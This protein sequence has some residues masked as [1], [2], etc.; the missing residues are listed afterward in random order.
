M[1]GRPGR[2]I[3]IAAIGATLVAGCGGAVVEVETAEPEPEPEPVTDP[4]ELAR[5]GAEEDAAQG[6]WSEAAEGFER[7]YELLDD[8]EMLYR[9]ALAFTKAEQWSSA[10]EKFETYLVA[11]RKRISP[12]RAYEIGAELD[13]LRAVAAGE[14]PVTWQ[15]LADQVYDQ[16]RS[17]DEGPP[18]PASAGGSGGA[19]EG[20]TSTSAT[21]EQ[22]LFY[23]GS[24]SSSVRMRAVRDLAG[25]PDD[26]ARLALEQ[27]AVE[28][29]NMRVRIAAIE[30]LAARRSTASIPLL[31]RAVLTAST[32]EERA[33]LKR[34]VA[35]IIESTW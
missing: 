7:A 10:I 25:Q 19:T 32:S 33:V 18:S 3:A 13:R 24:R 9:A 20:G 35:E 15:S 22:L 11:D 26:R 12:G 31:R 34:A 8:P 4:G 28:D 14:E 2:R 23:S 1:I 21:L 27:R 17:I 5:S 29:T 6:R 30:A 16:R